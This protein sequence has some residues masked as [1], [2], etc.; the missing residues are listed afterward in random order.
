M[1]TREVLEVVKGR[2]LRIELR[3][4]APVLIRPTGSPEVTDR[5]LNV[6]KFHRDP[7]IK[8]LKE[9]RL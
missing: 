5:L 6:L 2:G 4:G 8:L 9:G 7:I 3:D 1:S